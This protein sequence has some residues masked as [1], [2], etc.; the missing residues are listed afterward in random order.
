M[1]SSRKLCFPIPRRTSST[2]RPHFIVDYLLSSG[3][4]VMRAYLYCRTYNF[5]CVVGP[6]SVYCERYFRSYL[7][8]EVALLDAKAERLFNK[9][10]A[11]AFRNYC[12]VRENHPS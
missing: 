4:I 9:K 1:L 5:L 2:F 3:L 8:Y 11:A 7:E 12:R 10:R 6:E